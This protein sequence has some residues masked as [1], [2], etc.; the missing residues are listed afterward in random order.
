M[1]KRRWSAILAMLLTLTV[2]CAAVPVWAEQD[3]GQRTIATASDADEWIGIFLSDDPSPLA[4][5]AMT[6]QMKL[7]MTLSGGMQGIAASLSSLGTIEE[8]GA[9]YEGKVQGYTAFFIPCVFSTAPVDLILIVDQ[10]AL[11]GITTG[12]YSGSREEEP[13]SEAFDAVELNLPVPAL[14]GELP[15]ILT[16]P[17]GEGPF[18][19]VVLVHGSG[20]SDRDETIGNLK[21]FRDLAEG[22]AE[23]GIAVYRFDKRTYVYTAEMAADRQITLVDES[24]DDAAAAVQLLATVER[25]D[26]ARIVV[27][28][29]SLGGNAVPAIDQALKDQPVQACGYVM[30]AASPRPLDELIREQYDYLYSLLPEI[31]SQQQSEKDWMFSELDKLKDLDS[32]TDADTVAGIYAPYWKWLAGYDVLGTAAQIAKPCLLLQGEEDYQV[33]MADFGI[34]K[35]AFGGKENWRLISYPGLTHPFTAGQKEEGSAAY[36]RDAKVDPRVIQDIAA[37]VM[38]L[39]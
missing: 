29:H 30:M 4:Q 10:G 11:A 37:F 15:G 25:I 2:L 16:I 1:K 36:M 3:N 17:K 20:P 21:P 28:G 34:W 9:A 35:E 27:L 24:I 38:A 22:L 23:L 5:W 39:E 32:L 33:T 14:G 12:A 7:A 8:I 18:P 13:V 31:T 26:P 6:F 19:A